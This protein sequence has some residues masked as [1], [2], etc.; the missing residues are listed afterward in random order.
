MISIIVPIY[1]AAPFLSACV[2]S[3]LAQTEHEIEILL[4]DDQSTDGSTDIARDYAKREERVHLIEQPHAGQSVARNTGLQQAR[5]EFI[6]FVDA[7]DQLESDWCERHLQAIEGADYV[8]SGYKRVDQHA[9]IINQ[10][11]PCHRYQFTSPCMRL[12]RKETIDNLFF[13]AGFIYED[14]LFSADLWLSDA[15]CHIIKYTGYLY[16]LNPKSTTSRPHPEAQKQVF[17][18]LREKTTGASLTGKSIL[19]YTIIRLKLHFILS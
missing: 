17:R 16:T 18:A 11:S 4:V 8:Q 19:W 7:D 3:L 5:G 13:A 6:A 1:N 10:K 14:I 12:Y 15:Q 2:E 9:T